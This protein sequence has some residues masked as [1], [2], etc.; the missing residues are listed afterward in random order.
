[1]TEA[2]ILAACKSYLRLQ[3][4]RGLLS[5]RRIHVMP[6]MR[7]N[8]R[9]PILAKNTDMEG[10]EDLQIYLP[11]GVIVF[12]ECKRPDGRLSPE[13][14]TRQAELARLGHHYVIIRSLQDL[15]DR[16]SAFGVVDWAFPKSN[17]PQTEDIPCQENSELNK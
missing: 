16:L 6:V 13:Q 17:K 11:N 9:R 10:M 2:P 3:Q 15:I 7:G 12:A 14:R 1:M 8:H 5:F 4:N